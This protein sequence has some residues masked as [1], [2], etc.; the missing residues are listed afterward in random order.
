MKKTLVI[1][2]TVSALVI[3]GALKYYVGKK[4]TEAFIRILNKHNEKRY[5]VQ[6]G[7]DKDIIEVIDI[8]AWQEF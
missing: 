8:T 3:G 1:A 7:S 6:R 5:V 2:G 4:T